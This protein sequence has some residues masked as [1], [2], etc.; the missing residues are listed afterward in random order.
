M[1]WY[2]PSSMQFTVE[3]CACALPLRLS[4]SLCSCFQ[5]DVTI[6]V[7]CVPVAACVL[8]ILLLCWNF[9]VCM[10]DVMRY[11][12]RL[13]AWERMVPLLWNHFMSGRVHQKLLRWRL[14]L[15]KHGRPCQMPCSQL[16]VYYVL[17]CCV[18]VNSLRLGMSATCWC[19]CVLLRELDKWMQGSTWT[20]L[21][22]D[23]V[24]GLIFSSRPSASLNGCKND[25]DVNVCLCLLCASPLYCIISLLT[26]TFLLCGL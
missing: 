21:V 9:V 11:T 26:Y 12:G 22:S 1:W 19:A 20:M 17:N 5:L 7:M 6:I 8:E 15:L 3:L 10:Y 13:Y 2:I 14:Q 18:N 4:W 16:D 24:W 25:E 23:D